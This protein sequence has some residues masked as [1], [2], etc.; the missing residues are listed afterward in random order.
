M[1]LIYLGHAKFC[2]VILNIL[3]LNTDYDDVA[4]IQSNHISRMMR[5]K[6]L[7]NINSYKRVH[8]LEESN[9]SW[10]LF[11]EDSARKRT[12]SSREA[13]KVMLAGRRALPNF[14][15]ERS[16]HLMPSEERNQQI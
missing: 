15:Q 4:C 7:Q 1:S 9:D 12:H 10:H 14:T 3:A 2:L 16:S 8:V 6:K 11:W 13:S 5:R